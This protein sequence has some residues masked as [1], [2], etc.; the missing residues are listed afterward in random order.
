MTP[1]IWEAM[2]V[3]GK[4][5]LSEQRFDMENDEETARKSDRRRPLPRLPQTE[6]ATTTHW[7][8]SPKSLWTCSNEHPMGFSI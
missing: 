7:D 4:M 2:G 6:L 5:I 1:K 3:T 8:C